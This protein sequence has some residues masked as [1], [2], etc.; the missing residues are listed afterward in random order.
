MLP[1]LTTHTGDPG[2]TLFDCESGSKSVRW[3]PAGAEWLE[4]R[5]VLETERAR[6]GWT[7]CL[8]RVTTGQV[9]G[10]A[11]NGEQI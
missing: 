9:E 1:G 2:P 11:D 4:A 8:Q 6:Q 7:L 3:V 5:F 10:V